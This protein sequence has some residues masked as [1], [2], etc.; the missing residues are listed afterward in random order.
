VIPLIEYALEQQKEKKYELALSFTTN[1]YLINEQLIDYFTIRNL[2]PHFQITFDGYR[3]EHNKVR[4]IGTKGS[5]DTIVAN[6]K[7]LLAAG[8][9]VRAR[10]NYTNNNIKQ[11]F[12]IID[13][14]K[15]LS[16]QAKDELLVFDFHRVWQTDT[17]GSEINAAN[18]CMKELSDMMRD[19]GFRTIVRYSPNNMYNSCYA[20]KRNSVVIN[21]NGD[22]FKCTARDFTT[23][24]RAG[25]LSSDGELIWNDGY[26]EKR[27]NS[28][29]NNK[30]CLSCNILPLCNGG[31]SQHSLEH[32]NDGKDYCVYTN[33]D[34]EINKVIKTK[35]EEI[36]HAQV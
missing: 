32:L 5:Y 25:Y 16:Q 19:K 2:H 27:M 33:A 1:G 36:L 24:N 20:D 6:I 4:Y 11:A 3:N 12:C 7:T 29:L 22:I 23:E 26:M 34:I 31:C 14:F 9:H 17:G 13:D 8:M 28:K 35:V 10:I 21:Y 15:E 30:R 18:D